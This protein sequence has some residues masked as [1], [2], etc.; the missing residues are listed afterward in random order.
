[1]S[2][3]LRL[4]VAIMVVVTAAGSAEAVTFS[5]GDVFA[6][7]IGG[8]R[9]YTDSGALL[10]T[11]TTGGG[12]Y[13]TGMAFDSGGNLYV[14]NFGTSNVS[15]FSNTGASLGFFGSGYSTPESI[16]FD[17]A[18]NAY[19]GNLLNG[20]RKYSAAGAY[21]ATSYGGRVDW[22]DLAADQQTMFFTDEGTTI[23]RHDVVTNAVLPVFASGLSHAYALRILADG[24]VLV[25]DTGNVK[26]YNAAG[27]LIQTYDVGGEDTWFSLNLN[28]GGT[29]FW[30]GNFGTGKLYEFDLASGA[31]T[32]MITTGVG[33]GSLFG[34]A[35]FGEATQGCQD[36][37]SVP[38]PAAVVLIGAALLVGAAVRR[39]A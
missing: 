16:V 7:I 27:A 22:L 35:I 29:S 32:Q 34:V 1:M 24:G 12:S 5:N 15:K 14:T 21:L 9:H 28:P 2:R 31:M 17:N 39:L 10:E 23:K 6:A 19:V 4:L 13:N 30:S 36:C 20:I 37:G 25:A 3:G 38:A 33:N 26:R 11:L 18:G 8:V